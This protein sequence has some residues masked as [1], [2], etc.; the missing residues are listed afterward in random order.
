M[1]KKSMD[2]SFPNIDPVAFWLGPLPI[3][4]YALAYL[5]GFLL[6]WKY[7]LHL[8]GLD[9]SVR[10]S[11][12]DI[13]DFLP[14]TILGVILGGRLG[15]VLFY[16]FDIYLEYPLA[17]LKVWQ[18]GMS[19]HGG[20]LGVAVALIV[21]PMVRKFNVF[22]LADMVAAAA[23]IGLFFGRI[24][25]FINGELFGR[26]S[27]VPWA[28]VFPAGG[29]QPRHPSQLYEAGLEGAVLFVILWVLVRCDLVRNKPGIV[30]G[31][32][33]MG[34]GSFRMFVEL[35][36]QPD[37]HIGFIIEQVSM[38]QILSLPMIIVGAGIL[39]FA[40]KGR[41]QCPAP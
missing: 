2:L 12:D 14:W 4:W 3:R 24:S 23:P 31:A 38:G 34:Y 13:E 11:R 41:T 37:A 5:A 25:N 39:V 1:F 17:A 19:F 16:N 9:K 7:C 10:P 35:F 15:Y 29:A 26:V 27:D 32:F 21:Y 8:A 33:L 30:S 18:G 22:R 40:L 28:V 36:R 20:M 6:G